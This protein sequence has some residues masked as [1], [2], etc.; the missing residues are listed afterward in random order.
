MGSG[1][2]WQLGWVFLLGCPSAWPQ[3]LTLQM[4]R[5]N[6]VSLFRITGSE[7]LE[8][9][10]DYKGRLS[11]GEG[12]ALSIKR[13]TVQ[14]ARTFVCQVGAGTHGVGEN[15]TEIRVYSE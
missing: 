8:E 1:L 5:N 3:L 11:V 2:G 9:S 12:K 13:V 6:R 4:D 15:S 10:T 7:I 14:D